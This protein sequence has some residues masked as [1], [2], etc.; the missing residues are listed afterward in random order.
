MPLE[1]MFDFRFLFSRE[2]VALGGWTSLD[3][4]LFS[5][6]FMSAVVSP[7]R[8]FWFPMA[9]AHCN[10]DLSWLRW[11][12]ETSSKVVFEASAKRTR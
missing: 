9:P 4:C 1:N 3:I 5:A 11:R 2:M 7:L 8:L 12:V 6:V 10:S